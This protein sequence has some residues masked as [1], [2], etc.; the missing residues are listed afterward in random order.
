M[1]TNSYANEILRHVPGQMK[2]VSKTYGGEWAGACPWCGGRDRFRVWPYREASEIVYWCRGC[3]ESGDLIQFLRDACRM[4]FQE[5]CAAAGQRPRG[6][7]K[8]SV[9]QDFLRSRRRT[10]SLEPEQLTLLEK[11]TVLQPRMQAALLWSR[12]QAY[13][14]GRGIPLEVARAESIG[15]LPPLTEENRAV[16]DQDKVIRLWEDSL[17]VPTPSP[18]GMSY[19]ARTLRLWTPGM[20]EDEHKAVLKEKHLPRVLK[21]G[22]AGWFW[23]RAELSR[24]VILVEGAFEKLALLAAGF[25][26]SEVIAVG[27]TA[28]NIDWLPGW[29]RVVLIAFNGDERGR[30]GSR[31][32]AA[33]LRF[34]GVF[35]EECAPPDDELGSDCNARWRKGGAEGLHFVFD[36][37]VRAQRR[38]QCV[39]CEERVAQRFEGERGYCLLCYPHRGLAAHAETEDTT[40]RCCRC[41][42]PVEGYDDNGVPYC[43][44]HLPAQMMER[45]MEMLR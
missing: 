40:D 25:A 14:A 28:A 37:W 33:E 31:R 23:Q 10:L 3:G 19:T 29:V 35:V 45:Q 27:T 20:D 36:G 9:G 15:Y 1:T 12:P 6:K 21:T 42:A 13:L 22:N 34:G 11:L 7:G 8:G 5:A 24:A 38:L 30:Q 32:L 4:S 26:S 17:V 2:R 43:A 41:G 16:Y 44:E 39:L 18:S